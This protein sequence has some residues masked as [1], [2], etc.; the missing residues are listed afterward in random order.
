M[1]AIPFL[2]RAF[3]FVAA[4]LNF[5]ALACFIYFMSEIS[6]VGQKFLSVH[7]I[8][9]ISVCPITEISDVKYS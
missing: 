8:I 6:V 7:S 9:E 2:L 5:K 3:A 1:P 4:A